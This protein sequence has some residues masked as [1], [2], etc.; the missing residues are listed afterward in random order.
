M[1]NAFVGV[2]INGISAIPVT[3]LE[4][5]RLPEI[6]EKVGMNSIEFSGPQ[7][8]FGSRWYKVFFIDSR[9]RELKKQRRLS[10]N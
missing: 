3:S 9:L 1:N 6:V 2:G 8:V 4:E 10:E 7:G 5:Y